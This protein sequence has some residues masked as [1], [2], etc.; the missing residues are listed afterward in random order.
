MRKSIRETECAKTVPA[1]LLVLLVFFVALGSPALAAHDADQS[2]RHTTARAAERLIFECE[3]ISAHR[4]GFALRKTTFAVIGEP[5]RDNDDYKA[6]FDAAKSAEPIPASRVPEML[7]GLD[8]A[9]FRGRTITV[10]DE[11]GEEYLQVLF[12]P[13][14]SQSGVVVT[15]ADASTDHTARRRHSNSLLND[16]GIVSF[17]NMSVA[18][19]RLLVGVRIHGSRADAEERIHG[20]RMIGLH[21]STEPLIESRTSFLEDGQAMIVIG[22]YQSDTYGMPSA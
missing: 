8:R 6:L 13:Y 19:S 18:N 11:D 21:E 10:I 9:Y 14:R 3:P 2:V 22:E 17:T 16:Y 1:G 20:I 4:T 5:E 12:G 15:I 7:A